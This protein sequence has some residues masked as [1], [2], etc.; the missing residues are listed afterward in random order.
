MLFSVEERKAKEQKS[1]LTTR[2]HRQKTYYYIICRVIGYPTYAICHIVIG[3]RV[4]DLLK[5][6]FKF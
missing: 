6:M 2:R 3:Y 5:A 1:I 4:Q